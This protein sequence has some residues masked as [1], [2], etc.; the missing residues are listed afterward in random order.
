[1]L[2][3]GREGIRQRLIDAYVDQVHLAR[4]DKQL[5][6]AMSTRIEDLHQRMT[7][8][9]AKGEEGAIAATVAAM[10]DDEVV[11]AIH[12]IV[13]LALELQTL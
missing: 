6:P 3:E 4:S 1:M 8:V 13:R 5:S 7:R 12:E 10:K 9:A 2:A 11:A